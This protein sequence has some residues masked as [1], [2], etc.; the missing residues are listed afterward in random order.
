MHL[1][2][3]FSNEEAS[4]QSLYVVGSGSEI[5]RGRSGTR[6]QDSL[7]GFHIFLSLKEN[8]LLERVGHS[9]VV[10]F[11]GPKIFDMRKDHLCLAG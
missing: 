2:S 1:T 9:K 8:L 5:I 4:A 7:L 11:I 10:Q 3:V 6:T